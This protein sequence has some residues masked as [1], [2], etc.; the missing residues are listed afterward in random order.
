[1]VTATSGATSSLK[2]SKRQHRHRN[3]WKRT[4]PERIVFSTH[5]ASKLA[6]FA[7]SLHSS[8]VVGGGRLQPWPEACSPTAAE[9]DF[10][11]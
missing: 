5:G 11:Q 3:C 2:N 1:M 7:Q 9:T 10:Q 8:S 4:D 6:P